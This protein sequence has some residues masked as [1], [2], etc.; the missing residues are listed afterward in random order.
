MIESGSHS[1]VRMLRAL[2]SR[3]GRR[4]FRCFLLEG[5]RLVTEAVDAAWPL[6]MVLFD[7]ERAGS[8]PELASLVG[9]IPSA[10]PAGPRAIKQ[11]ADTVTPQGIVAAASMPAPTGG[12]ESSESLILVMDAISDPGNAGTLL[13]S[14]LGTAVRTVLASGGS[15]DLF[16]PK[17]VRSGMGAHFGL[18]LAAGLSW[19]KIA[20]KLGNRAV[21]LADARAETPYYD[22]DWR[23]PS[24]LIVASEAHGAS[25][26]ARQIATARVTI[27][28]E[29][30]LESL[31]AAVAGS[32]I[33]FE[34]KR[35]R[36]KIE[37]RE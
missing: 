15:V 34:A 10:I 21:V 6:P 33:L 23:V 24:A 28:L 32:V 36:D 37:N 11:A 17:V 14:A 2:H 20:R 1:A 3:D 35:Q 27:P 25:E 29:A 12:I 8:D 30:S 7:A 31:N 19:G 13:R 18:T 4:E 9:R 22:Y 5:V 26:E 16:S